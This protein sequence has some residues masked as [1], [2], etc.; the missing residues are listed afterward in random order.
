MTKSFGVQKKRVMQVENMTVVSL[1]GVEEAAHTLSFG[2]S[3]VLD[4]SQDLRHERRYRFGKL[5]FIDEIESS[6]EVRILILSFTDV[7]QHFVH[8]RHSHNLQTCYHQSELK[9]MR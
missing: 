1:T 5:L 7:V 6:N 2:V 8:M 4:C 3:F 9:W